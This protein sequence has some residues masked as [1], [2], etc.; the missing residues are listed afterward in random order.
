MGC[1]RIETPLGS[2]IVCSRGR[3][4]AT[5]YPCE[6]CGKLGDILCDGP[7]RGAE[8]TCDTKLCSSCATG[9]G[10]DRHLCPSC[11]QERAVDIDWTDCGG[12]HW[13]AIVGKLAVSVQRDNRSGSYPGTNYKATITRDGSTIDHLGGWL[14]AEHAKRWLS[15][16]PFVRDAAA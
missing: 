3:G 12:C 4:R 9:I 14:A 11:N 5:R 10:P 16:H 15:K 8:K 7:S 1:D 13:F 6:V 2:G